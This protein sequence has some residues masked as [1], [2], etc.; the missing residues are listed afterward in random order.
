MTLK[1]T[2]NGY[3]EIVDDFSKERVEWKHDFEPIDK[4]C[5]CWT[6]ARHSRSYIHHLFYVNDMLS[7][8]MLMHHNLHQMDK[9]V[10][11]LDE[12]RST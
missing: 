9:F 11:M 7:Y 3:K 8:V 1:K 12:E 10:L 2:E 4:E 6:C 5:Q